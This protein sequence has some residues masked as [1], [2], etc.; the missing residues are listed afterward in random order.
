M[1]EV[2]KYIK[3]KGLGLHEFKDVKMKPKELNK[4]KTN[5]RTTTKRWGG[6]IKLA[7]ARSLKILK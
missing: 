1:N 5:K 4:N 7:T 3:L 6:E 2:R